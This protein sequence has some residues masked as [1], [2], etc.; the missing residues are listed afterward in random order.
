MKRRFNQISPY[1]SVVLLGALVLTACAKPD[2]SGSNPKLISAPIHGVNYTAEPFKFIVVDPLDAENSGGGE[3][4]NPYGA[5]GS[6]CCYALPATWRPGLIVEVHETYWSS[7]KTEA[8]P[9]HVK[10]KHVVEVPSYRG[11]EVGALWVLR[12][13]GGKISVLSSGL[14]PDHKNWTGNTKGWPIPS[15]EYRRSLHDSAIAEAQST[16]DLFVSSL[17]ELREKPDVHALEEWNA[18]RQHRPE[19]TLLY[20]GPGD[21]AFRLMLKRDYESEVV[22]AKKQ[23][24]DRKRAKP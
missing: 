7:Q 13:P 20:K 17:E 3:T 1:L 19:R 18:S 6:M 22:L 2:A 16:V 9:S 8:I 15:L 11:G 24:E 14:Q 12:E 21:P 10:K 5:G 4:V 23:L